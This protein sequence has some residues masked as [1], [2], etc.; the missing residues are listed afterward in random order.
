MEK[1]WKPVTAGILDIVAGALSILGFLGV[2]VA[3]VFIPVSMCNGPGSAPQLGDW[4]I[5]GVMQTILLI[6]A[7]FLLIVGILPIIGGIYAV[8]RKNRGLALAGS[9]AAIL[10][11][12]PLGIAAIIF[13]AMSKDEFK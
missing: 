2:L 9:I 10:I 5:P 4:L 1:T 12:T 8:Q 3:L 6:A 13:T 7:V 11:S